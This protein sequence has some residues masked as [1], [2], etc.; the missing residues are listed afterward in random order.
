MKNTVIAI[1]SNAMGAGDDVLGKRLMQSFIFALTQSDALPSCIVFYNTG[2]LLTTK[3]SASLKDIMKLESAGVEV[4]TCG[5]CLKHF[6]LE[7]K[8]KTGSQTNMYTI[9]ERQMNAE[10]VIRP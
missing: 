4:L 6:D 10:Q 1:A 7:N 2:A 3:E 9:L 5:T 8:L